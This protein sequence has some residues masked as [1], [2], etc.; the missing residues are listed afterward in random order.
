[1][2]YWQ[3]INITTVESRTV[4]DALRAVDI[5]LRDTTKA[6]ADLQA[7]GGGGGGGAP[8]TASYLTVINE[9]GLSAERALAVSSPITKSDGGPDSSLTIGLNTGALAGT[10]AIL[11]GTG[12]AAGAASTFVRTDATIKHPNSLMSPTSLS[13][14][15]LSDDATDQ[16]LTGSLGAL[17]LRPA[18]DMLSLP[19]WTGG[20]GNAATAGIVLGF[21]ANTAAVGTA[22][23]F[24]VQSILSITDGTTY[25]SLTFRGLASEIRLTSAPTFTTCTS[26]GYDQTTANTTF[27]AGTHSFTKRTG[28]LVS[29]GY[30]LQ[31]G[32]GAVTVTDYF[33]IE[34][35]AWPGIGTGGTITNARAAQLKMPNMG[36]TVRRGCE[37]TTVTTNFGTEAANAEGFYCEDI[38]R[39][40]ATRRSYTGEGATTGTPTDV[41]IF[42]QISVHTVGTNRYFARGLNATTLSNPSGIAQTVLS[43][44]QLNTGATAGAH[45]NFDNKAG[46]P[47][48]PTTGDLWRNGD[49]LWFRKA[50]SS[51]NL[52]AAVAGGD[53]IT[54]NSGA[55]TATDADFD[56]DFPAPPV[57]TI[58]VLWQLSGAS[59]SSISANIGK[60][61]SGYMMK[62]T[63]IGGTRANYLEFRNSDGVVSPAI[64]A[65]GTAADLELML[66][67]KGT[68]GIRLGDL[69]A[70]QFLTLKEQTAPATPA[71]NDLALYAKD[72]AAVSNL[73]FMDDAGVE[74]DLTAVVT[75]V[76]TI[77][78]NTGAN[79]GTRPRINLIEGSGVTLTVTDDGVDNEVDVT[80]ATAAGATVNVGTDVLDF[81]AFPGAS[82]A[83]KFIFAGGVTGTSNIDCWIRPVATADHSSDEHIHENIE[84]RLG[85]VTAGVGFVINGHEGNSF[86]DAMLYGL[87]N[88][89]YMWT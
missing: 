59:P 2:R 13:L 73:Y 86:G 79:V 89:N 80:V 69:S 84:I 16:T 70:G 54:L 87:W 72:K 88:V 56:D 50:A 78:K 75:D 29:P 19:Y 9:A 33:G 4:R 25:S 58:N 74:H 6:I 34:M 61:G 62:L 24:G 42:D 60:V 82:E 49:G 39:G 38:A 26:I 30:C 67:S 35:Q 76:I 41:V 32:G 20:G 55:G 27:T 18:T 63:D 81:G 77:R 28:I 11:Y 83:G 52:A 7:G 57:G 3:G 22:L 14:L 17:N 46:D 48:S 40:T 1:M 8:T 36:A 43:L 66:L 37:L 64:L 47:P 10:P 23:R 12:Y 5:H 51:V 45:V 44:S 71:A 65:G 85:L 15:T 21:N 53:S 68:K 31:S